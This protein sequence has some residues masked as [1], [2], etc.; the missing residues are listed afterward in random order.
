MPA[1]PPNQ[2]PPIVTLY[3][4]FIASNK[5]RI[6]FDR[7]LTDPQFREKYQ[8]KDP[9][10]RA[11]VMHADDYG[12]FMFYW[13]GG[14]YV[15]IEGYRELGLSDSKIDSL[16]ASPNVDFLRRCRNGVFHFQ[17]DYID[18]RLLGFIRQPDSANWVRE[19][20]ESFSEF[21]LREVPALSVSTT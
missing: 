8:G 15:V 13:Y 6:L 21:F 14:L 3:R 11:F 17:K 10:S 12:V 20:T 9:L 19:L 1:Q 16:L 18:E 7:T 4:Y 5:M 2:I